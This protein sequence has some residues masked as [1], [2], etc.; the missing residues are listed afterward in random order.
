MAKYEVM[1]TTFC[2]AGSKITQSLVYI[3]NNSEYA[4][5]KDTRVFLLLLAN[6]TNLLHTPK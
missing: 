5:M 4:K 2:N 1:K 3:T 6:E